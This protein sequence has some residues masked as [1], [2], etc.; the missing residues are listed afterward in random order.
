MNVGKLY[1]VKKWFWLLYPSR[2]IAARCSP[3]ATVGVVD[4][5]YYSRKYNCNVTYI[6]PNSIFCLLEKDENFLKV[7]TT[8][9]ELG[10]MINQQDEA[11]AKDTIEEIKET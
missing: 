5:A 1:Q 11:W 4:L 3:P 2:D 7:L 9:G 6:S 10:W 8:N